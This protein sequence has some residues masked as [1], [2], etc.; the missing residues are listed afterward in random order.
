MA[1]TKKEP[2]AGGIDYFS[3][4]YDVAKVINASLDPARVLEEIARC[5]TAAMDVKACSLRLIG[6]RGTTLELGASYGLSGDYLDKG[7]III[8][9]SK[10]DQKALKGKTIWM[11]DVQTD[12]DF[13]YKQ[14]AKAEGIASVLVLPLTVEK[15]VIGVLRVYTADVREFTDRDIKFLEAVS[16]LSAIAID[17]A[18]HHERLKIRC[19][20]MAEHKY[21]IDDL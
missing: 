18:R 19:D 20:L 13:Q 16:N 7:P 2:A 12:D 11:K 21:R 10:V 14:K 1:R 17:N 15:T 4:L 5:V 6:S 3:A 9:E 8:A